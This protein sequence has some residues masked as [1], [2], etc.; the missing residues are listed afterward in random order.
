[1]MALSLRLA[2]H[3]PG[4]P[5]REIGIS[6]RPVYDGHHVLV[7]PLDHHSRPCMSDDAFVKVIKI[8]WHGNG[9]GEALIDLTR[10]V[11]APRICG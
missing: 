11:F 9:R 7:T 2:R 6:A 1:M 8:A 5:F 4:S 10:K 3:L